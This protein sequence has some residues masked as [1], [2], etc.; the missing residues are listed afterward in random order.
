MSAPAGDRLSP[1]AHAKLLTPIACA[2]QEG[3][4]HREGTGEEAL[5]P[6]E[7]AVARRLVGKGAGLDLPE[8]GGRSGDNAGQPLPLERL[9]AALG[10][11]LAGEGARLHASGITNL[12]ACIAY[13]LIADEYLDEG[14]VAFH[15]RLGFEIIGRFHACGRKFGRTYDM[16]W[17]EKLL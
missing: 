9:H 12:Y 6:R 1:P 11:V 14:S 3:L 8:A 17:M 15:E 4:V 10:V 2:R 13:P 5:H 16:V 7:G